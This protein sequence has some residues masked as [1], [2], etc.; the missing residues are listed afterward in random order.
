MEL[1]RS[2]PILILQVACDCQC[3]FVRWTNAAKNNEVTK[4]E[5]RPLWLN[6]FFPNHHQHAICVA[7]GLALNSLKYSWVKQKGVNVHTSA[8]VTSIR[9]N[10]DELIAT[11]GDGTEVVADLMA[12]LIALAAPEREHAVAAAQAVGLYTIAVAPCGVV[13]DHALEQ[14]RLA[15]RRH[16]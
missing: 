12:E 10:G 6:A 8:R 1:D 7:C 13:G 15:L 9:P 11:L 14:L 2:F 3:S 4:L 16:A 5:S